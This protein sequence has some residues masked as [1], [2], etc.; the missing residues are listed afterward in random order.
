LRRRSP[1]SAVDAAFA[2]PP[3]STE[4]I[5]HPEKYVADEAPV[6]VAIAAPPSLATL[7]YAIVHSTTWGELGIQLVL[8]SKGLD[9]DGAALAAAGWS[10]DRAIVLARATA[11]TPRRSIGVARMEWDSEVDALEA[12]EAFV[13]AIDRTTLGAVVSHEAMRTQWFA[14]DGTVSWVERRER[15]LVVAIGVPAPHARI[16]TDEIWTASTLVP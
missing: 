13:K 15:S 11:Q 4:Q 8:R 3:K 9:L 12:T 7:G 2:R 1:W 5:L 10:G 16:L 6:A 14:L